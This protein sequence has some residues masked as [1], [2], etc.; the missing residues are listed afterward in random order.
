VNS[1]YS[2]SATSTSTSVSVLQ[3]A[4]INNVAPTITPST[5]TAGVTQFS[6]N[7]NGTWNPDDTDGTYTYL[8]Q[9]SDNPPTNTIFVAPG[10]NNLSTYTP[11]S[12]FFTLGGYNSPIRCRVTATNP[13]GSTTASSSNTATVSAPVT[14]PS[15]GTVSI[16]TNTGNYNVGSIITYSTTGWSGSPTSY[17]LRLYNGTNPVLT[18]DPLRAST[19]STSGTYTIASGDVP[20][21]FKAFATASNSAGTS[22][23]ASSTQV[24]P[25]TQPVPVNTSAPTIAPTS[26]TAG[27]TTYSVTSVG[28]WTNSPTSYAY[29]WQYNDQGATFLSISGATSSSYSPPSNFN[30]IYISPIRCSVTAVNSGGSSAAA[31]SNTASVSAPVVTVPG[32]VNS[33]TATSS[34]SGT[35]LN[36]SASWSAPSSDG[37]SAITGYRIYVERAGSSSGPWLATT[38]QSPAGTGAFTQAS[39]RLV[40]SAT[41]SVS[42]RVTGTSAT[43]IRVWVAAVNSVGTG[44]YTSAVG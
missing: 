30:S 18:S 3:P 35:N 9:S 32:T 23:E 11:P 36:W 4:P 44:S 13:S 21:F 33:L 26:G 28:S 37:G 29:Q 6:V 12:N 24:G 39:P 31:F 2:T 17:S 25:A 1:T 38:T 22:A 19:S 7:S 41:T 20:N 8:W 34:L 40:S 10:T 16:S 15:G 14:I 5:G 42:G 27:V 43:W